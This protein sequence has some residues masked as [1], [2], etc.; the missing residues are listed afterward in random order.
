MTEN[1]NQNVVLLEKY[2]KEV[3]NHEKNKKRLSQICSVPYIELQTSQLEQPRTVCT[4]RKCTK[5]YYV[6]GRKK[7]IY[8]TICCD[9]CY[10]NGV[11]KDVIGEF[12]LLYCEAIDSRTGLC[13][14]CSCSYDKHMHIYYET[15][16]VENNLDIS[17]ELELKKED[18]ALQRDEQ[19]LVKISER[20]YQMRREM[21]VIFEATAKFSHFLT[22]NAIIPHN[23]SFKV[24]L[25]HLILFN[26]IQCWELKG[27]I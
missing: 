8:K 11:T 19:M 9:P 18:M 21:R 10:L 16:L 5:T 25:L 26:L 2:I 15:T 14:K 22:N 13:T 3:E 4:S 23:D 1:I 17:L 7:V 24:R 27:V 12:L 20:G 6:D